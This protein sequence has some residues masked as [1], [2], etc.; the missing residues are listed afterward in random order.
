MH[1]KTHFKSPFKSPKISTVSVKIIFFLNT[2]LPKEHYQIYFTIFEATKLEIQILQ[3]ST[4]SG[5]KWTIPQHRCSWPMGP[6]DRGPH[7]SLTQKQSGGAVRC[8][9]GQNSP[10]A[11]LPA[12]R[13][14]RHDP[15]DFPHLLVQ[16]KGPI[17]EARYYGGGYGGA[18]VQDRRWDAGGSHGEASSSLD[19]HILP[20]TNST[21]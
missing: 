6:A 17:I 4:K 8:W 16:Q 15:H 12:V 13:S 19:E 20:K 10:T 3:N 1:S 9:C 2:T 11:R 21:R 14:S 7:A 5:I 18:E